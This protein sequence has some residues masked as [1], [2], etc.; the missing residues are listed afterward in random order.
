MQIQIEL[1]DL[2]HKIIKRY[3]YEFKSQELFAEIICTLNVIPKFIQQ[4]SINALNYLYNQGEKSLNDVLISTKILRYSMNIFYSLNFQ[5]I[6]ISLY[7]GLSR[8]L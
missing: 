3:R 1:Y 4:D 2:V 7:I 8:I 5:V 6:Y